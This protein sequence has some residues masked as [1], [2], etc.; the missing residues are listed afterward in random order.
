MNK[1]KDK[2]PKL[3]YYRREKSFIEK[4]CQTSKK[5]T[6]KLGRNPSL[7]AENYLF[8]T[9]FGISQSIVSRILVTWISFMTRELPCLIY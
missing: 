6:K 4:K 5:K 3:Q 9:R 8:L 2:I 7:S 1:I